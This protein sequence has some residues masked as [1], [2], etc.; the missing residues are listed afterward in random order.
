[1]NEFVSKIA[2]PQKTSRM[3]DIFWNSKP[4]KIMK[5]WDLQRFRNTRNKK[6]TILKPYWT[7]IY[8]YIY[9]YI[10]TYTI[11][12]LFCGLFWSQW[13]FLRQCIL[14]MVFGCSNRRNKTQTQITI[15]TALEHF[16][17]KNFL[18][19]KMCWLKPADLLQIAPSYEG[20]FNAPDGSFPWRHPG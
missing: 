3:I 13:N 4:D 16:D 6:T 20:I 9:K 1:M 7:T 19:P 8:I 12:D 5:Q 10:Y 11:Y 14:L 18:Y 15:Y 17:P 2:D